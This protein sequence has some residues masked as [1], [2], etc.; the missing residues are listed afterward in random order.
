MVIPTEYILLS[1]YNFGL[2]NC[3]CQELGVSDIRVPSNRLYC[4]VLEPTVTNGPYDP[5]SVSLDYPERA[6]SAF[7]SKYNQC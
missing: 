5:I 3:Y 4:F 1:I 2:N 6:Q 7:G